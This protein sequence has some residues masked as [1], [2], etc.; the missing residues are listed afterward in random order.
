MR[1]GLISETVVAMID[2]RTTE[3]DLLARA[4]LH[5]K[6]SQQGF[7]T[8]ETETD[9][10][11]PTSVQDK[12]ADVEG[13]SFWFRHRNE[14]IAATTRLY[15]PTG[16]LVDIGG[17]NGCVALALKSIGI[18]TIVVEPGTDGASIAY[19]RGLTVVKSHF[20][21]GLFAPA[22]LPSIGLFDVIEHISDDIQFL[23]ECSNV[24]TPGGYLYVAVPAMRSLWSA[25]DEYAGHFRRYSQRRLIKVLEAAGFQ[26]LYVS[27]FFSLLV[28]PLFLLRTA[29]SALGWRKVT[30]P[31][32]ALT[33]HKAGALSRKL[34]W[35]LRFEILAISR[36]FVVPFG[37]S[38]I[39]VARKSEQ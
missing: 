24:M 22:S 36:G 39:A 9:V 23:I 11:Y 20:A 27:A 18:P 4:A 10:S 8:A 26:T 33:H 13:Q 30:A 29:P 5:L 7:W 25:D 34:E 12:L 28:P 2:S 1:I 6:R 19:S 31:D 37:T 3:E 17:G 32:G 16:A 38:V 15:P 21:P 35:A 14:V